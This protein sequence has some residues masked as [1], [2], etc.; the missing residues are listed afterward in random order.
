MTVYAPSLSHA[1]RIHKRGTHLYVRRSLQ[2]TNY[3]KEFFAW[4]LNQ[5]TNATYIL[6][7]KPN[8]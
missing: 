4:N 7:R 1:W 5:M 3:L 8:K 2:N 6:I